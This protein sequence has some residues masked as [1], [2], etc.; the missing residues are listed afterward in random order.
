[1]EGSSVRADCSCHRDFGL[2]RLMYVQQAL[3]ES[4]KKNARC[5]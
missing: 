3:I 2:T 4:S 5:V 1:M